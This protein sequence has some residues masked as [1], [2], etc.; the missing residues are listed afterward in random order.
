MPVLP[1]LFGHC[2]KLRV[3]F[4]LPETGSAANNR[5]LGVLKE[6]GMFGTHQSELV[7]RH[8]VVCGVEDRISLEVVL[9]AQFLGLSYVHWYVSHK[10]LG[11]LTVT[12]CVCLLRV[13]GNG[14]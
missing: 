10:V 3:L 6:G 11:P 8:V 9:A 14:T 4:P 1:K 12:V 7:V 2:A 13:A 5:N